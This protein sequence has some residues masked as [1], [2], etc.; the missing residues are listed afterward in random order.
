[1]TGTDGAQLSVCVTAPDGFVRIEDRGAQERER[2]PST[3]R[4]NNG[5]LRRRERKNK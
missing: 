1:M 5:K 2:A 3:D 4:Q